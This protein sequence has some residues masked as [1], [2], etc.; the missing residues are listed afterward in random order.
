MTTKDFAA[1]LYGAMPCKHDGNEIFYCFAKN[2]LQD[3]A[4]QAKAL[5]EDDVANHLKE[6]ERSSLIKAT[7]KVRFINCLE[8]INKTI[9][10]VLAD[11]YAGNFTS[12]YASFN[13]LLY[14][15]PLNDYLTEPYCEYL[16]F[17]ITD[18]HFY[19]MR[20]SDDAIDNCWHVPFN[21]RQK[22]YQG[23]FSIFGTPMLYLA[24]SEETANAEL[25]KKQAEH[26]WVQEFIPKHQIPLYDLSIP[27]KEEIENSDS[28]DT[29]RLLLKY[30][31]VLLCSVES[32]VDNIHDFREVYY[33]PQLFC[34]LAFDAG[35]KYNEGLSYKGI[36]YSST[37]RAGGIN[38]AMPAKYTGQEPPKSGY[39][40]I[41]QDLFSVEEVPKEYNV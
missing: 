35:N 14:Q 26:R 23:R 41:L 20:D 32:N 13:R 11:C 31:L 37:K 25:G 29:I 6:V 15:N 18:E 38:I 34:H 36:I 30:P 4:S 27:T 3:F 12:A 2:K 39:S 10:K 17:K 1:Q 9:L 16:N 7:S 40:A 5:D 22:A 19:R 28:Y 21:M 8:K 24:D 33:I